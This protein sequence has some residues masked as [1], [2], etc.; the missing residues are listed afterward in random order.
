MLEIKYFQVL[1]GEEIRDVIAEGSI[2]AKAEYCIV[3]FKFNSADMT[4]Y[5]TSNPQDLLREW[6]KEIA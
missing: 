4:I 1:G 3:K 6:Q 2:L 5:P